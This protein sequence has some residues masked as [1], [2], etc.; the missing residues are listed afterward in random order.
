VPTEPL[1]DIAIQRELG[2]LPGWARRGN[3]LTKT[4]AFR[5]F[6]EAVGF[7]TRVAD[8]ATAAEHYP[9]IDVRQTRVV[10][11]LST[12]AAGARITPADV[13][14]ARKVEQ[15]AAVRG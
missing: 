5:S 2:T 9:D 8:A 3:A 4:F 15:A 12:D 7:V 10:V 1:S 14:L 13:A 6:A 11:A